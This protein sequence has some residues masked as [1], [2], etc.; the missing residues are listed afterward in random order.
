MRGCVTNL[1]KT[2]MTTTIQ[3]SA[4]D[5][6]NANHIGTLEIDGGDSFEIA[7]THDKLV[8]GT[9]CNAGL[10]ESGYILREDFESLDETLQE[11]HS[12]LETYYRDG[13]AYVSRIVCNERM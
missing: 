10:L 7:A 3:W 9:A 12:D 6:T 2:P 4:S 11:L 1:E 8:F 13:A 5:L